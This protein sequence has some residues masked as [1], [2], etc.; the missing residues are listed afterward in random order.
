MALYLSRLRELPLGTRI[1]QCFAI[2]MMMSK[3][4]RK[5]P[6]DIIQITSCKVENT[7]ITMEG[8]SQ[9][10]L[11][12]ITSTKSIKELRFTLSPSLFSSQII[13]H[14]LH[15][16][17]S[18]NIGSTQ[19]KTNSIVIIYGLWIVFSKIHSNLVT[20]E[21]EFSF[22][23]LYPYPPNI[24]T[25][26]LDPSLICIYSTLFNNEWKEEGTCVEFV[27]GFVYYTLLYNSK[28]L[29]LIERESNCCYLPYYFYSLFQTFIHLISI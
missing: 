17:L 8:W 14:P 11:V 19:W 20:T 29:K 7:T 12:R 1:H 24:D 27:I 15:N 6:F 26:F 23:S 2:V 9:C 22:N 10:D 3:I 28:S 5:L 21:L 13:E 16:P 4:E 18:R 25:S